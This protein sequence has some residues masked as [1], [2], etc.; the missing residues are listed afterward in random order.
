M[1]SY[2]IMGVINLTPDSFSDGGKFNEAASFRE[3]F[4][5]VSK[6]AHIVDVG[7]ESTA[8]FNKAV[9]VDTELA[10]FEECFYPILEKTSDPATQ[11]SIDTYKPDV[12]VEVCKK[13]Y[14]HWPNCKVI[15]NDVSGTVD[16]QLL[17]I[18]NGDLEFTYVLSHNLCDER[19]NTQKHMQFVD[20]HDD[21]ISHMENFFANALDEIKTDRFVWLD[22]CFGFSKTREQNHELLKNFPRLANAF[23]HHHWV[24]GISRKSFLRFP[25]DL[26][27]KDTYNQGQLDQVQSYFIAD[28]LQKVKPENMIFRVHDE[29]TMKAVDSILQILN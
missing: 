6:W 5:D 17:T 4:L 15:W 10:R 3:H 7:A 1:S 22:P 18:L 2:Q 28:A 25:A 8:P 12:F 19:R 29:R 23:S 13:V 14:Q 11:V 9:D 20:E 21:L 16:E 24:Y 26:D 27:S